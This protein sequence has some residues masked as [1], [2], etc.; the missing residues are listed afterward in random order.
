MLFQKTLSWNFF[1]KNVFENIEKNN[2]ENIVRIDK[3]VGDN[4]EE[5]IEKEDVY[6]V[7]KI[8]IV[9][10]TMKRI[11]INGYKDDNDNFYPVILW[12]VFWIDNSWWTSFKRIWI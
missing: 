6:Y 8:N 5:N 7:D 2:V 4:I 9:F 1:E 12:N 11:D 3:N 10:D